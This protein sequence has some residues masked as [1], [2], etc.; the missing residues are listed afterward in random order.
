MPYR[1]RNKQKYY[2][3]SCET[4][5]IMKMKRRGISWAELST[6]SACSAFLSGW[7]SWKKVRQ[8]FHVK[9]VLAKFINSSHINVEKHQTTPKFSN[10]IAF[11]I[12]LHNTIWQN[13][14][15]WNWIVKQKKKWNFHLKNKKMTSVFIL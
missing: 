5:C 1:L 4:P 10:S 14:Q 12:Q 15:I 3:I 9:I 2:L 13:P 6:S 11:D 7:N 8:W